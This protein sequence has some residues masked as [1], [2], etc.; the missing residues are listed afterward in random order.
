MRDISGTCVSNFRSNTRT[1]TA[2]FATQERLAERLADND[3]NL[4]REDPRKKHYWTA[5][6][7]MPDQV[8][9]IVI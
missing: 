6:K 8:L 2:T 7:D 3:A 4:Q 5:E 9:V 1:S